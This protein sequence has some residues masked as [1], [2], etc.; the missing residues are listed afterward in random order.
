MI[1]CVGA[2]FGHIQL[3]PTGMSIDD[4]PCQS[5]PSQWSLSLRLFDV[6]LWWLLLSS[7]SPHRSHC[8]CHYSDGAVAVT[9]VSRSLWSSSCFLMLMTEEGE[10]VAFVAGIMQ[11]L[12]NAHC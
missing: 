4:Y 7:R 6:H 3:Y 2:F 11:H 5:L 10:G 8:H 1:V 12:V 9:V